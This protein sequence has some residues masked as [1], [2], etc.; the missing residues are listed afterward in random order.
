ML[1]FPVIAWLS[2]LRTLTFD[3]TRTF[4]LFGYNLVPHNMS[5]VNQSLWV[6]LLP[7]VVNTEPGAR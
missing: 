4:R 5:P 7:Q 2:G 6:M 3:S 1:G